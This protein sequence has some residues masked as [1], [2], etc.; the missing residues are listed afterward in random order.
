M[1]SLSQNKRIAKHNVEKS[2]V[3][4]L[5]IMLVEIISQQNMEE[6]F[7]YDNFEIRLNSLLEVLLQIRQQ[8]GDQVYHLFIGMLETEEADRFSFEELYNAS[9]EI[10]RVRSKLG[11][12]RMNSSTHSRD[13][14]RGNHTPTRGRTDINAGNKTPKGGREN[15]YRNGV[16]PF[17]GRFAP[18]AH[19][20]ER[21]G[22]GVDANRMKPQPQQQ[23]HTS[24]SPLRRDLKINT[25]FG[26]ESQ[27]TNGY[28]N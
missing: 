9:E 2:D 11:N 16:S 28:G 20:P 1:I 3:Y 26:R 27:H 15:P 23:Q 4:A 25:Q 6:I 24:R 17:R 12:S 5:G 18:N 21:V 10:R 19:M 13:M 14:T 22:R 8:Y 7:D